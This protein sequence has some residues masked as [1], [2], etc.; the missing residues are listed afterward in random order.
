MTMQRAYV[1]DAYGTLLDVHS[2]VAKHAAA[3]GRDA[4]RFS[5]TWRQKQLEYSWTL[6]LM[7]RY[8]P[9]WRLTEH[10]LDYAFAKFPDVDRT[11]RARLLDAYRTLDA[12]PE[13]STVL[14]ALRT[15]GAKLAV[16]SNGN[17]AMLEDAFHSAQLDSLLDRI[18]SVD[19]VKIFKT[20]PRAYELVLE[21]LDCDRKQVRFI[22]SNR[23]DV[24]GATAFGFDGVWVN[25]LQ[26]P[27]EYADLA[28]RIVCDNLNALLSFE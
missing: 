14:R 19:A 15:H 20:D 13:V 22:S 4:T 7:Q 9:F 27:D 10:A 16:L 2:A 6:S 24:A 11:L 26:Q 17:P 8:E 21:A 28:P 23:W 5:E 25:R 3:I 1:F 18:L 12:F